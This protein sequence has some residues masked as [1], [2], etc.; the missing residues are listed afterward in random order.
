[1]AST[2]NVYGGH[3]ILSLISDY[4][5]SDAQDFGPALSELTVTFHFP[6]SGPPT[7]SLE[8]LY[9]EFHAKRQALPKVVFR[10]KR[11]QAAIDVASDLFDGKNWSDLLTSPRLFRPGVAE[12]VAALELLKKRLTER[13]DF[14]L[15]AFLNHCRDMQSRLPA[16]DDEID[17]VI[18]AC[19]AHGESRRAA[20][21][22]WDKLDIDWRDFHPNARAILD[23]PFYW[24]MANDF[25]P[26]GNDTGADLL[27]DY[28]KW[29]RRDPSGDPIAFCDR[30]LRRWGIPNGPS[31]EGD[32]AVSDDAAVA[33]A[34]AELKLRGKCPSSVIAFAQR[35]IRRQRE[36]AHA[37]VDWPHRED[38]LRRLEML[39]A[40][41]RETNTPS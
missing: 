41:L 39:E 15:D 18:A 38:R 7:P 35:A 6:H 13:D 1:M 17:A 25:A 21:S 16:T 20:M 29:L 10:R 31:G 24:D 2:Y 37:A 36:E 19:K 14:R 9:A 33:L 34:F 12:M 26:H 22:P 11:S 32:H 30:L 23:H 5:L 4:L 40:K 3:A 8:R 28:R 27:A